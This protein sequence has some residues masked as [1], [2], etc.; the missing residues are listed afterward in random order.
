MTMRSPIAAALVAGLLSSISCAGCAI[1][2][3]PAN[4]FEGLKNPLDC[5]EARVLVCTEYDSTYVDRIDWHVEGEGAVTT[6]SGQGRT[7][8]NYDGSPEVVWRIE[9]PRGALAVYL[10]SNQTGQDLD[11]FLMDQCGNESVVASSANRFHD[12]HNEYLSHNAKAGTYFVVVDGY[13]GRYLG[14]RMTLTV[15]CRNQ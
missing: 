1:E 13:D 10:E 11:L 14:G 2:E 5:I 9:V 8:H 7:F 6:Y 15:T 12:S 4:V 3:G